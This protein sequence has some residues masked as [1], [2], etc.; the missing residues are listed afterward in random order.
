MK[1]RIYL[2]LSLMIIASTISCSMGK[3]V[4]KDDDFTKAKTMTM[5]LKPGISDW[6]GAMLMLW[7]NE[8]YREVKNGKSIPTTVSFTI[9]GASL[10]ENFTKTAMVKINNQ[11]FNIASVITETEKK[12]RTD[13]EV[14]TDAT[15]NTTGK[16]HTREH[17]EFKLKLTL[18]PQ[19]E[20]AMAAASAITL[21][22][23]AGNK[24]V[25][26]V[27]SPK[28]VESLKAFMT[29]DPNKAQK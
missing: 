13:V 2:L 5:Y 27:Y 25:T 3:I 11:V 9:F 8:F 7:E 24:P 19:I 4:V 12:R 29:L 15:G 17:K 18:T 22:M 21:R 16:A 6:S 28:E 14:S 23:N 1:K 26:I 10:V 20:K